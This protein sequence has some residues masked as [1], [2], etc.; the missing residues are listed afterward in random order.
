MRKK[1]KNK[2]RF[3]IVFFLLCSIPL[4]SRNYLDH[5]ISEAKS[6]VSPIGTIPT[7]NKPGDVVQV[8]LFQHNPTLQTK[9][10]Y[11]SLGT[12]PT[13]IKKLQ[14]L[15]SDLNMPNFYLKD[16]GH[17]NQYFGG[18]LVR[19]LEFILAD[20]KA[21]D[22]HYVMS[23]SFFGAE[24]MLALAFYAKQLDVQTISI[25][26]Y[27]QNSELLRQNLLATAYYDA[28]THYH[29][30]GLVCDTAALNIFL[31]AERTRQYKS[32][33]YLISEGLSNELGAVAFVNAAFELKD[34]IDAGVIPEPDYIFVP[35][36]TMGMAA[37][38]LIGIKALGL[39]SKVV[40]VRVEANAEEQALLSYVYGVQQLLRSLD[41]SFMSVPITTD[42]FI[43]RS[44]FYGALSSEL[45]TK[46]ALDKNRLQNRES[47]VLDALYS[48]KAFSACVSTIEEK[49]WYDKVILFWNTVSNFDF[50]TVLKRITYT[51]L[52]ENLHKFFQ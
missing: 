19:K 47:I 50:S 29:P 20:A 44:D 16:D 12:L 52:P 45:E 40:C 48:D 36:A 51:K 9:L 27:K 1:S 24:S 8:S 11:L 5:L 41:S 28:E 22:A 10:H 25:L 39:K 49:K 42:D 7:N 46:I 17:I 35:F 18:S 23:K 33:P 4:F 26:Y 2:K 43:V 31:E 37:G 30:S 15:G 6:W 14:S 34:Q 38:L 21:N 3:V 13:P 32:Y